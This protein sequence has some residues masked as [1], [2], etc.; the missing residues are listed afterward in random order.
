MTKFSVRP[1]RLGWWYEFEGGSDRGVGWRLTRAAAKRAGQ[2]KAGELAGHPV[3]L[4]PPPH[5]PDGPPPGPDTP[6]TE[7]VRPEPRKIE[8]RMARDAHRSDKRRT[9]SGRAV[10][11]VSLTVLV[12]LL[13]GLAWRIRTNDVANDRAASA[14]SSTLRILASDRLQVALPKVIDAFRAEHP[15]VNVTVSFGSADQVAQ[16]T[17]TSADVHVV[18]GNSTDLR[19]S[20]AVRGKR[21]ITENFGNDAVEMVA[22]T[23]GSLG[24]DNVSEFRPDSSVRT[25]ICVANTPCGA[26]GRQAVGA[27]GFDPSAFPTEPS[28]DALLSKIR[29]GSID[30][31]MVYRTEWAVGGADLARLPLPDDLVP[32]IVYQMVRPNQSKAADRFVS[33]LSGSSRATQALKKAGL[34]AG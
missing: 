10:I 18:I 33:F 26:G 4:R 3:S 29:G 22:R 16:T 15:E 17:D 12:L 23:K 21:L 20:S 25:A 32:P 6:P 13:G 24:I 8:P 1:A 7:D 19:K 2:H 31:G 9:P 28:A 11:G 5:S 34:L 27:L 30:A 14:Q